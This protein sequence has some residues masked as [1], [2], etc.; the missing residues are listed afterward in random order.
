MD[1]Y[2]ATRLIRKEEKEAEADG[3]GRPRAYIIALTASAM[4]GDRERCL[5][6][7]MDD[8]LGKPIRAGELR[9]AIERWWA[10]VAPT[11]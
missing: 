11:A 5:A 2:E 9:Q 10:Q 8:Y 1:G 4:R 6:V 3:E 7:G